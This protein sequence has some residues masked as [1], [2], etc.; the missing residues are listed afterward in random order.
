[1]IDSGLVSVELHTL[2]HREL[3]SEE[4]RK[5]LLDSKKCF[6]ERFGIEL[7]TICYPIGDYD[8]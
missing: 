1:M 7:S 8:S 6:E 2:S 4:E 5:E 3:T